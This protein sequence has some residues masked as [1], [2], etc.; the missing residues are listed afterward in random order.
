MRAGDATVETFLYPQSNQF[1]LLKARATGRLGWL[2]VAGLATFALVISPAVAGEWRP[3][4]AVSPLIVSGSTECYGSDSACTFTVTSLDPTIIF[5]RWDLTGGDQWVAPTQQGLLGTWTTDTTVTVEPKS[6]VHRA[7][8]LV[9]CVQGWDGAST[10]ILN[11]KVEP[12]GPIGCTQ[13]FAN[14][15]LH[16]HPHAWKE[17]SSVRKRWV[18]AELKLRHGADPSAV[19]PASVRLEG[20]PADHWVQKG[21][22]HWLFYFDRAALTAL[23][24]HGKHVV[25]MT[26][27]YD[28][29]HLGA[30]D[31]IKIK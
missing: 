11:G 12:D 6:P 18:K 28:G 29:G 14:G 3:A 24:G 19:D 27:D 13:P 2:V 31:T 22:G 8:A 17:D 30:Y 7:D 20:L 5:Y 23:V 10:R 1:L 15:R 26:G 9:V 25:H 4:P 16:V 21:D